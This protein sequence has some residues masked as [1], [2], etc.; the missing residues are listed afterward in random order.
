MWTKLIEKPSLLHFVPV[1]LRA[2]DCGSKLDKRHQS[3]TKREMV[4][5]R[6]TCQGGCPGRGWGGIAHNGERSFVDISSIH[7]AD[8]EYTHSRNRSSISSPVTSTLFKDR[9]FVP[10]VLA[11]T[12]GD[13]VIELRLAGARSCGGN[14]SGGVGSESELLSSRPPISAAAVRSAIGD[15]SVGCEARSFR[16]SSS[17]SRSRSERRLHYVSAST[18][19]TNRQAK[20]T[21]AYA[22][23]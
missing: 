3:L 15:G 9:G 13:V 18:R 11:S 7:L 22:P 10:S 17:D 20:H 19:R 21:C 4:I 23:V 6:N 8:V 2:S 5:V 16:R 12:A 1:P 14:E